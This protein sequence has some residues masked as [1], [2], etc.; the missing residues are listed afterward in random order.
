M[1]SRHGE[2]FIAVDRR[3]P[4]YLMP[5]DK[6]PSRAASQDKMQRRIGVRGSSQGY[7]VLGSNPGMEGCRTYLEVLSAG[8]DDDVAALSL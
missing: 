6:V 2:S 1:R 8:D 7:R 5:I 3:P 4:D